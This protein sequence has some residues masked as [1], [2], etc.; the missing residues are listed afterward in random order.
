MINK[1]KITT[2]RTNS[3]AYQITYNDKLYEIYKTEYN[4]WQI[5]LYKED[6]FE[7]IDA[8]NTLREG[9]EIIKRYNSKTN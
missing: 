8:S 7:V 9:K 3:G 6:R 1:Q 2:K 4:F 5:S